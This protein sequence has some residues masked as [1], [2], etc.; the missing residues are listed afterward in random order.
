[1][2]QGTAL[3]TAAGLVA[4]AILREN[5]GDMIRPP[6]AAR[7]GNCPI[8]GVWYSASYLPIHASTCGTRRTLSNPPLGAPLSALPAQQAPRTPFLSSS[9]GTK[10]PRDAAPASYADATLVGA[11]G[12]HVFPDFVSPELEEELVCALHSSAPAWTDMGVR[13]FKSYGPPYSF[14]KR[15]FVHSQSPTPLPAYA[16][17]RIL[18]LVAALV[19]QSVYATPPAPPNQLVVNEYDAARESHILPHSDCENTII[20]DPILGLCLAA[21]CTMTL[22][23][24]KAAS[25]NGVSIKRDV[26]LPRRC[27]YVMGGDSLYLWHHGIFR[28]KTERGAIRYSLTFRRTSPPVVQQKDEATGKERESDTVARQPARKR[29]HQTRL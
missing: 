2:P 23:L 26:F 3:P 4:C 9:T 14:S 6:P 16:T 29:M 20:E 5:R 13:R 27:L 28:N 15:T 11:P 18:P 8:C 12:F 25:A 10:R 24:P 7:S 17:D 22:I 1:M 21:A 19:P